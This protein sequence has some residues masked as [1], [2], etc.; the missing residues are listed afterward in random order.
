MAVLD[1]LILRMAV[2]ELL[3]DP[4]HAAAGRH[5]RSARAGAHVQHRRS[6]EVHQRHARR[7]PE[8]DRSNERSRVSIDVFTRRTDRSSA[9]R[10]SRRSARLGVDALSAHVRAAAHGL[11]AGRRRTAADARRARGRAPRDHHERPHPR[12]PVVRQGEFPRRSPTA[13]ARIQVYIRQDSLPALDFQ[14]FKLLD[15]GDWV[16][17]EG[18]LFRTK[19]NELTIWASRLHFLAK[20]LLPLPEKW[21]G[22]TD[23]EI[24]YRQRYLDLDRQPRLAARVRDAQPRDRRRSASS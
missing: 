12:D 24:R 10:T 13:L 8:E 18:R 9:G 14:I 4:R 15:F 17:V 2:C 21:H 6:G 22:L 19:T 7:D 11:G 3:R 1:R 16:G 23:V 20:C 5:Q